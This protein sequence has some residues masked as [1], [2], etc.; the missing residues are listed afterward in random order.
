MLFRKKSDSLDS[1]LPEA[2]SY[3]STA[4]T[5]YEH[6]TKHLG[7]EQEYLGQLKME[8]IGLT[9]IISGLCVSAYTL[10]GG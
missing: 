1:K 4:R 10:A 2:D 9:M 7:V 6:V 5:R 8:V 3:S